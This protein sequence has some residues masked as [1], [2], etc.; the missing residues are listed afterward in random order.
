MMMYFRSKKYHD[1]I[2]CSFFVNDGPN[3]GDMSKYIV[4]DTVTIIFSIPQ[5]VSDAIN[6][7]LSERSGV[8]VITD[9]DNKN[10]AVHIPFLV[11]DRRHALSWKKTGN[12]RELGT[13]I[14]LEAKNGYWEDVFMW[15]CC[16]KVP[17]WAI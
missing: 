17:Q 16:A 2:D 12:L 15:V 14:I 6:E 8:R 1:E 11:V 3:P 9:F 7:N 13:S 4:G 5:N 10:P